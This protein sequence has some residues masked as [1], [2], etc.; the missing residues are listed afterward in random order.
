LG[1]VICFILIFIVIIMSEEVVFR[2]EHT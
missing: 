1:R 2:W